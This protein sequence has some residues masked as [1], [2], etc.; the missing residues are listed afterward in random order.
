MKF[1]TAVEK[2]ANGK[3]IAVLRGKVWERDK[4]EPAEWQVEAKDPSPNLN[5]SPGTYGNAKDA[6]LFYDNIKVYENK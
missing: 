1:R 2:D 4:K 5:G 3:E 6:E